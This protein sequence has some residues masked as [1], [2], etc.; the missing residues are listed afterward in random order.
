MPIE[1]AV[2]RQHRVDRPLETTNPRWV[3]IEPARKPCRVR[4]TVW[5]KNI[6]V[7]TQTRVVNHIQRKILRNL[8]R[9]FR[10]HESRFCSR[11]GVTGHAWRQRTIAE[12]LTD[13]MQLVAALN[14]C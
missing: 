7:P 14:D 1:I 5:L 9:C 4:A 10:K 3:D 13:H 8:T 11:H 2:T 6:E 12:A